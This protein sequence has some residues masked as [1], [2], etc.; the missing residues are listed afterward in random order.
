MKPTLGVYMGELNPA[1]MSETDWQ[2]LR[3]QLKVLVDVYC[4]MNNDVMSIKA[5]LRSLVKI[6]RKQEKRWSCTQNIT[7]PKKC[8]KKCKE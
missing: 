5:S 7:K 2:N 4:E 8:A 6:L 3:A 1:I